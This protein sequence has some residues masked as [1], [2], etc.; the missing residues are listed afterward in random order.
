[1]KRKETPRNAGCRRSLAQEKAKATQIA[2]G[3][4]ARNVL[5]IAIFYGIAI[6]G[7]RDL[8]IVHKLLA[9]PTPG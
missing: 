3:I 9:S 5:F 4:L 2:P 1:M 6:I 8:G 7:E